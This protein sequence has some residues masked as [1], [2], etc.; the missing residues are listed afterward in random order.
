[1]ENARGIRLR[2]SEVPRH[3]G[4]EFLVRQEGGEEVGDG[5]VEVAGAY[6]LGDGA[7]FEI[8]HEIDETGL[9]LL[10]GH[11]GRF[12]GADLAEC[13]FLLGGGKGVDVFEDVG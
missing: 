3:D 6:S 13:G 1:M 12:D 8:G 11:G 9:R 5:G 7:G 4:G 2:W 10:L